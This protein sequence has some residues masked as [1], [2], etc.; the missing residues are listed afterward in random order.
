MKSD[1][2]DAVKI[3]L[4]TL[5]KCVEL[6]QLMDEIRNQLKTMNHQVGFYMN[7]KTTM[8][9]NHIGILD[10]SY[11]GVSILTLTAPPMRTTERN[12]AC[13]WI[14]ER[15]QR[16]VFLAPNRHDKTTSSTGGGQNSYR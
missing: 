1:G 13:L 7:H 9:N 10:Q 3:T 2:A 15:I 12:H 11:S 5:N 16:I 14:Q 4:Y 8:K 6:K